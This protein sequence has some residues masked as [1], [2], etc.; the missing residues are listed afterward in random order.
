MPNTSYQARLTLI[1]RG[2]IPIERS[3]RPFFRYL[4]ALPEQGSLST[5]DDVPHI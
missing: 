4:E 1:H 5:P 2:D 3:H